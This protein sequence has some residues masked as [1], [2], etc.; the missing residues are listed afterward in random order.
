M[1]SQ[2]LISLSKP[3]K[4]KEES[5][6]RRIVA[7]EFITLDGVMESPDKW[8][9][10]FWIEEIG[11][12][13]FDELHASDA[14]LLGRVTYEIFAA[15]WPNLTDQETWKRVKAAGGKVSAKPEAN[16][17]A[18]RMNSIEKFVVST[19]LRKVEWKNSTLIKEDAVEEIRK[20]K[21]Q[22]GKD[23]L[24]LGSAELVNVLM[25][26]DLIDEF[27]LLVYPIVL[28]EGKRL[29]KDETKTTLRLNEAKAFGSGVVLL[30]YYGTS[31]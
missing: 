5:K 31:H 20:L 16:P 12:F 17:F 30:R 21:E 8:S 19:A 27:R 25:H 11:K 23:I 26:H 1:Q 13:K 3:K 14:L 2:I 22:D 9:F 7:S 29:F 4:P 28:G 24:I 10:P 15:V 18:D 6:M